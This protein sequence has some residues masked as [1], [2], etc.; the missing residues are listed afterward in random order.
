M[1]DMDAKSHRLLAKYLSRLREGLRNTGVTLEEASIKAGRNKQYAS[2]VLSGK[3]NPT[4]EAI[5]QLSVANNID[6][7]FVF[8]DGE[9]YARISSY[10]SARQVIPNQREELAAQLAASFRKGGKW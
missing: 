3:I 10:K 7:D 2:R 9:A 1:D 6:P 5:I 4:L 8:L